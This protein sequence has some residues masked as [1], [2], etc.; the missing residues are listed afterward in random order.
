MKARVVFLA[1]GSLVADSIND[2][3]R[4]PGAAYRFGNYIAPSP[5]TTKGAHCSGVVPR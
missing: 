5:M 3:G 4:P 1:E 2:R